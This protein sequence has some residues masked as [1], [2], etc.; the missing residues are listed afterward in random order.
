MHVRRVDV[1][2]HLVARVDHRPPVSAQVDVRFADLNDELCFRARRLDDDDL[3]RHA[4]VASKRQ[5]L[6]T[7]SVGDRLPVGSGALR[8][9]PAHAA[10][11]LDMSF[12]YWMCIVCCFS[13]NA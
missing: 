7:Y 3:A 6:G 5:M 1:E 11:R 12:Q 4:A 8:K 13:G 9:R 2:R 10:C